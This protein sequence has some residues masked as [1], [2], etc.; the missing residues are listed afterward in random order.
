M[1]G[2]IA[3][4]REGGRVE[5]WVMGL[6][7]E[8]E[9]EQGSAITARSSH[10]PVGRLEL[11][12]TWILGLEAKDFGY[13]SHRSDAARPAKRQMQHEHARKGAT[14]AEADSDR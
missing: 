4:G 3:G 11:A 8:A 2:K 10:P 9:G 14:R 5:G 6:I 12:Q 1:C 7:R 13:G